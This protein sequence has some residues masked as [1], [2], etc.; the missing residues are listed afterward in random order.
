MPA[1]APVAD[2]RRPGAIGSQPPTAWPAPRVDLGQ[3]GPGGRRRSAALVAFAAF[4]IGAL[5]MGAAF[6]T[7]AFGDRRDRTASGAT[8]TTSKPSST[9]GSLDVHHVLDVVQPSVVTIQTGSP[10]SI[11]GSAG[12]GVIISADGLVLTNAHVIEGAS[13]IEV[14]FY[15]GTVGV[16]RVVGSSKAR[17]IALIKVAQTG[18]TPATLGSS[19]NLRVGDDVVAIGNALNLGSD[20]SVTRGIVSAKDRSIDDGKISLRHL[21]QTDAAINHGNSGGP[22]VNKDGEVVGINT[23]IISDAQNIGFSIAIDS[24]QDL[25]TE[26]KAGG[27]DVQPDVATLGAAPIDVDSPD[28]DKSTKDQFGITA[29]RGALLIDVDPSGAASDAGIEA[30]DVVVSIDGKDIGTADEMTAEVAAHQPKD[31]VTIVVERRGKRQ[32]FQV[33]LGG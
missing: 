12:T 2:D 6:A 18:L 23:A 4:L 7:Y 17:D 20:P 24:I 9:S 22:L 29:T 27:G 8:T 26:L 33:T 25:I 21:I 16:A 14:H 19:A 31:Q 10:D 15:D 32:T 30:G 1:A 28:L 11:Y 5:V 3:P 13:E